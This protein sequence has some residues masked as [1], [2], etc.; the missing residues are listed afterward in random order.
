MKSTPPLLPTPPP[1]MT[2]FRQ[3]SSAEIAERRE[4]GLCFNCDERFSR[5]HR[6]KARFLLLIAN[7]DTEGVL[8]EEPEL[9]EDSLMALFNSS[10]GATGEAQLA[11]LSY[12][13]MSGVQT[14]QTIRVLGSVAQHS[15]H[16]LVDGGSTL[17]FIQTHVARTLGLDHTPSPTLK[18]I[19][20]N[21]DELT[22]DRV[23][24]AVPIVIQGNTFVVDLYTL[25]LSGPDVV[26]GTPWLKTLGPVL[27]D[28]DSLTMKFTHGQ[29]GGVKGRDYSHPH[30]SLIPSVQKTCA[31]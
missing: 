1:P 28:Y 27:M 13:A 6:C 9:T 19:V 8:E 14:A 26:L 29:T 3:L 31:A 7:T 23:C 17:N 15:V 12:H 10:D 20:G 25:N 2:R 5:N 4:K 30:Q 21:G 24:K 11:Q 22:S 16:V 18:V